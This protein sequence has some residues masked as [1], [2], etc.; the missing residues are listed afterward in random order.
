M[1]Y[2]YK[3]R[4]D[5]FDSAELDRNLRSF[6][7]FHSIYKDKTNSRLYQ[8]SLYIF[9]NETNQ[10]FKNM[11][12]AYAGIEAYGLYFC[13]CGSGNKIKQKIIALLEKRF[14]NVE[15]EEL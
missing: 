15:I 7:E 13:D 10:D 11:P 12:S 1:G 6:K 5:N 2:E 8:C 3:F 14:G 4:I 9:H